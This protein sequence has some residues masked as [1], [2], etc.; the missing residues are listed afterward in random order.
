M[1]KEGKERENQTKKLFYNIK[2]LEESYIIMYRG[3]TV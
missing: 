2:Q 1:Y 3:K